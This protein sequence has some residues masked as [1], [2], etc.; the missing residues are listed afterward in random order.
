[1][2]NVDSDSKPAGFLGEILHSLETYNLM[3]YLHLR[4]RVSIS[5]HTEN[6][7]RFLTVEFSD[8]KGDAFLLPHIKSLLLSLP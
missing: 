7:N 4:Q 8:M 2:L 1:M 3:P 6:G 5:P